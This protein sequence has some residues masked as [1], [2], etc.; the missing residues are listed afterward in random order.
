[1]FCEGETLKLKNRKN[2][3]FLYLGFVIMIFMGCS[4][5]N[6]STE[7]NNPDVP[8]DLTTRLYMMSGETGTLEPSINTDEYI[9]TLHNVLSP[10]RWIT[11]RPGRKSGINT[12]G[13]FVENV[14]P[15]IFDAIAPN[16]VL[17]FVLENENNGLFLTL[18]KPA[19]DPDNGTLSFT[20]TLLR[21]TFKE[22]DARLEET[23]EGAFPAIVVLN[24]G[25]G[26]NFVVHSEVATIEDPGQENTFTMIQEVVDDDLLWV[27]GAP[28]TLSNRTTAETLADSW[29]T[30]FP[31]APPNA[32]LFG[33]TDKN[34]LKAYS[35]TLE[36]MTYFPEDI[37]IS[38]SASILDNDPIENVTLHSVT[39]V[40]DNDATDTETRTININNQVQLLSPCGGPSLTFF[41]GYSHVDVIYNEQKSI[42]VSP[43]WGEYQIGFQ[44]NGWYWRCGGSDNCPNP[45][46]CQ[47]PDNAGQV[48]I[49][50]TPGQSP[51]ACTAAEL[52]ENFSSFTCDSSVPNASN[53][54][55]VTL[56][57][58]STCLVK[59][60]VSDLSQL[61]PTDNCCNCDSCTNIPA[62]QETHCK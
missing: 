26:L 28:S 7:A 57:D 40:I 44:V 15:E 25:D 12:V 10:V 2:I 38:Y 39:L 22:G 56:E 29:E 16:A 3:L 36:R 30:F 53:V 4:N 35:M 45:K 41:Q 14:W 51:T 17:K 43:L 6:N 48:A 18:R 42:V 34:Q 37:R 54:V 49:K 9:I 19:Y 24:N 62:G 5:N 1:M 59:V 23:I 58:P 55:T 8:E 52:V 27:S 21:S 46:N 31:G 13:D 11:D 47:N 50:I 20:A 32:F 60:E 33:I 61:D